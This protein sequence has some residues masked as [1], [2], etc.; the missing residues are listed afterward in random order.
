M[1]E[2]RMEVKSVM[3]YDMR[4]YPKVVIDYGVIGDVDAY[5]KVYVKVD[6]N[7]TFLGMAEISSTGTGTV[8]VTDILTQ[9]EAENISSFRVYAEYHQS[10]ILS[11]NLGYPDSASAETSG[12]KPPSPTP[13]SYRSF[14][15]TEYGT[16]QYRGVSSKNWINYTPTAY[17]VSEVKNLIDKALAG[18]TKFISADAMVDHVGELGIS[19]LDAVRS[20]VT[21]DH[22]IEVCGW[23]KNYREEMVNAFKQNYSNTWNRVYPVNPDC[24]YWAPKPLK[25]TNIN[26]PS[27]VKVNESFNISCDV[28]NSGK[29]SKDGTVAVTV[30]GDVKN[31]KTVTDVP[32]NSSKHVSFTTSISS[33]GSHKVCCDVTKTSYSK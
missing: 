9:P 32:P 33:R 4:S 26:F 27:E 1:V 11:V 25:A 17:T 30:D 2:M 14:E 3:R 12:Y 7:V 8:S 18:K 5:D 6:S 22:Y 29:I 21:A 24:D 13:V 20:M 31:K 15:I 16:N 10:E 23:P 28:V 19:A